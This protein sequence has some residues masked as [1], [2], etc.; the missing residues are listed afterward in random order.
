MRKTAKTALTAAMFA[1]SLGAAAGNVPFTTA[2]GQTVT[3][4]AAMT[5]ETTTTGT[6]IQTVYGPTSVIETTTEELL[7]LEGEPVI[8]TTDENGNYYNTPYETTP[9]TTQPMPL[10]G[11]PPMPGDI[12][13]DISVDVRDLSLAKRMIGEFLKGDPL[14]SLSYFE[15]ERLDFNNDGVVNKED[16]KALERYLTGKPEDEDDPSETDTE[17][18]GTTT[19]TTA[20]TTVTETTDIYEVPQPDYG[21]PEWFE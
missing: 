1:A 4:D 21:P 3:L 17:E 10:Y 5:F 9:F 20:T 14:F 15:R 12:N 2:S 11:P 18:N 16:I 19:F 6:T 7:Q 8:E 13:N